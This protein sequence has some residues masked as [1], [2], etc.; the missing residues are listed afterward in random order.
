[1]FSR[2]VRRPPACRRPVA[3][4]RP[5]SRVAVD[6]GAQLLELGAWHV[7]RGGPGASAATGRPASRASSICNEHVAGLHRV[8]DG[9]GHRGH[10][11]GRRRLDHM[12]HLHGLEQEQD[13]PRLH[14][15]SGCDGHAEHGAGEG[16]RELG[17]PSHRGAGTSKPTSVP[18]VLRYETSWTGRRGAMAQVPVGYPKLTVPERCQ[19]SS[20]GTPRIS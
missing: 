9:H 19:P 1:M 15:V 12:L 3:A 20:S 4:G 8:A 13:G 17:Q 10:R 16:H 14:P 2:A 18:Q 5:A 11:P 6:P 7:A